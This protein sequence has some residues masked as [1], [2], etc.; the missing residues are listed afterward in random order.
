M[1]KNSRPAE[2]QKIDW[3]VNHHFVVLA[4]LMV[5]P[6]LLALGIKEVINTLIL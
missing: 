2:D 5:I 6:G 3:P 4:G 1:W